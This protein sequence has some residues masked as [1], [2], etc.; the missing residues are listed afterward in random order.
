MPPPIPPDDPRALL[1][2]AVAH[3]DHVLPGQAPILNFVHHNTLHGYQ[4]LPFEQAL[5][6]A[7]KLT[8]IRGY[9]ADA[10]FRR[11]YRQGR[12][13]D[14]DL[15]AAMAAR[16]ALAS[17]A[18]ALQ[19]GGP[20]IHNRD[21]YRLA[22]VYGMDAISPAQLA[23]QLGEGG[24]LGGWQP[25]LPEPR[26]NTTVS[27]LAAGS[28]GAQRAPAAFPRGTWERESAV[29]GDLWNACLDACGIVHDP[30]HPE[31][32]TDLSMEQA[33]S[34]F[35]ICHNGNEPGLH[36]D[37]QAQ[38]GAQLE[39]TLASLGQDLSLRGL[40]LELTGQDI[41]EQV[42]P[43]LIRYL[44]AYLDEG[45]AAWQLPQGGEGFYPA[46]RRLASADFAWLAADMPEWR[47]RLAALPE[48]S[49]DAAV[50]LL[51]KLR[52][53]MERWAGYVE[54][55]AL[56]IPGWSGMV[57]W[58]QQR[59]G[60]SA[61]RGKP[62]ALMDYLAVRLFLDKMWAERLCRATWHTA[63]NV[64]SLRHYFAAN[65]SEF[66]VRTA[67]FGG[68]LPEYL[69]AE[70]E[71]LIGEFT[72]ERSDPAAWRALADRIWT[73][74]HTSAADPAGQLTAH[75]DGWRLFRLAQHLGLDAGAM[76]RM[77]REGADALL[78]ALG[79]MDPPTRGSVWLNAYER[80]YRQ[81]IFGALAANRRRGPWA[82]RE[83]RPEAQLIFCM[84]D[85][86]EGI[87]RHLEE[88]NPAVETLG[89]AGFFGVPVNWRGLDDADVTPLCPVVVTP[90]NEVREIPQPGCA[91]QTL[92]H[93][94][95]RR[96]KLRL[97]RLLHQ[98]IRRNLFS[99]ALAGFALAPLL[100]PAWL[101]QALLP[102]HA[103]S[104]AQGIRRR[105]LPEVPTQLL[106][107]ALDDGKTATPEQPRLGFTDGEQAERV[108]GFLRTVGLTYGFAKLVVLSGHGSAS[109]NNPHLAAYD[110]GACSGRHGGP[111]ARVFAAMA[112]RPAVRQL[113]E[114]RGISIPS[115]TWF[116]GS[117]HNTADETILWY[118]LERLPPAL[119]PA[120]DKLQKELEHARRLSAHERC[121][122]LAS[123][124]R[125]P[126][127]KQ[128]LNHMLGRTL[129]FSQIRPELGHATNAA[130]FIGRRSLS[131]GAFF[132]RRAFLIS[133]DPTQ[134]AEG[135]ILENIL[136][137][138]GPVGAGINLEYYF[139]T[140]D[141]ER[142]GCGSKIPHN[143]TGWFAV[144]EGT[145]GDLRT[146]LPRQMVE[147]HE[148]M[149][150]LVV[151]EHKPEVVA[152]IY[153][154]QPALRELIG[155]A[156]IQLASVDPD[157][158]GIWQFDPAT[159]SFREWQD[160]VP[161]LPKVRRSGDWY[162][163]HSAP[164]PPALIERSALGGAHG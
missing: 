84:D 26:P 107:S 63:A 124:P 134:D 16:P 140:V 120:L 40:L 137:A 80:H 118:D 164:L 108:A 21:V 156:W 7:E 104:L 123:A 48:N 75:R 90:A 82:R 114:A 162:Q 151:T 50:Y 147:I 58:R 30:L 53:P 37:V 64:G 9:Q 122:R 153:A 60:Y 152:A 144:M 55:L 52:L 150:L 70:A 69:A 46:W 44:G 128:A 73:W 47:T 111:N 34:L 67:L 148:A 85:R 99:S 4:H 131:R 29:L 88:L 102:R 87:R 101:G 62:V 136:L 130:A 24:A 2:Q 81:A 145:A 121:R 35:N 141:N 15:Y 86:E 39:Q 61:N 28:S 71:H 54:R 49:S 27:G 98:E 17:E 11:Y 83:T 12:I 57:N 51:R 25:D 159:E 92:A 160:P 3:L 158:G 142:Y 112:N 94:R 77:G 19:T 78:A 20:A 13:G 59:P 41:L 133:Y 143:V 14:D 157:S 23:W 33:E 65:L 149:R 8:G 132:D 36:R 6:Q 109:R 139:S 95:G 72:S 110:C 68:R 32:L 38:A 117:E 100:L 138:A 5:A 155:N 43:A 96:L 91:A 127:L 45:L 42:R 113:L 105:L 154:R 56:E 1:Q 126:S 135:K 146:G 116:I 161:A 10:D 106:L 79:R 22:L 115:D 31:E 66:Q 125:N 163:G 89:A 93:G 74:Q 103:G 119:G 97:A 18:M 76:R 129:D